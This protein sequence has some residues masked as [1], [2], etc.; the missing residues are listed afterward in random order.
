MGADDQRGRF[1]LRERLRAHIDAI[2]G[3][4]VGGKINDR[5]AVDRLRGNRDEARRRIGLAGVG[6]GAETVVHDREVCLVGIVGDPDPHRG[7]RRIVGEGD[8]DAAWSR[9]GM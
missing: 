5:A 9:T 1:A 3:R 7:P 6:L 2:I 4:A 8:M